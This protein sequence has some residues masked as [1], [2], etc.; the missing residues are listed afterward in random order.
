MNARH[1][2]TEH[3]HYAYRGC[4]PDPDQPTQSA[5]DPNLP[6]DAWTTSTVDGGLPQRERV[7][8]QKAARAI[9]GRCPVLDACRAYGNIAIPGGGLVEPVGIWGGQ[10]ALNRHRALI[11]LRTAQPATAE[12]A[13]SP[14]RIAEAGT[15]AKL[16]VLRALARETDTELVAYRAGM[17]V[18]TANWHRANLCTLLGLD[19]ETTTREQLLGVAKANRLLPANVRIVPDGRWPIA[20]GPTTDGARQR[21]LAP[22]SPSPSRCPSCPT[23]APRPP[24]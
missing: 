10:T 15:V 1:A 7:E 3:R 20:A 14:G 22:D 17:D 23:P 5:A 24:P 4:A 16:R 6:L 11:A 19:K 13:P 12:P 9:C 18:R 21:R 8:Q 2:L